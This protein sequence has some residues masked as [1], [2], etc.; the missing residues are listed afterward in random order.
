MSRDRL[1][2]VNLTL[3][4]IMS[5]HNPSLNHDPESV[6]RRALN[7]QNQRANLISSLPEKSIAYSQEHPDEVR[8][9]VT[10]YTKNTIEQLE[11]MVLPIDPDL[12]ADPG[13]FQSRVVIDGYG[14]SI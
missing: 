10:T 7:H 2:I 5:L 11:K 8:Q 1:D 9:I 6:R 12:G 13:P 14:V 3:T 4:I